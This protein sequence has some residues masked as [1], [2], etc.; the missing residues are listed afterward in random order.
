MAIIKFAIPKGSLE[1]ATFQ[2]L[3]QAGYDV[4]GGKRSYRPRVNDPDITL[5]M[6]RPQEIPVYVSEGIEDIAITGEDWISETKSDVEILC[7]LEY[8]RVKLVAGV[9]EDLPV[10][11]LSSLLEFLFAQ[12]RPV[13]IST[14]YLKICSDWVK[15]NTIY[16]NRF[17]DQDPMIVTP[18]WKIGKNPQVSIFLSFG[19]TEA[20]PPEVAD[21]VMDVTETGSTFAAN[22]IKIIE[23]VM[24]SYA[25]LIANKGALADPIR[26]EK[27][28][29]VLALFRGVV[30]GRRNLHIFVNVKMEN[31]QKLLAALPALKRPT[32][33]PLSDEG[34]FSVNTVLEKQK[35]LQ[36]LPTLRKLAQ[37]LVVHEPRQIL[38]LEEIPK[39]D[40]GGT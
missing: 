19:A 28:Y 36:I 30:S 13:R 34:W 40:E 21:I 17:G 18:W 3:S 31:L 35:F 14:E 33:N 2:F 9:P 22:N 25:V 15:S 1:E 26:R 29:D 23:T 12:N 4:S 20:K 39:G 7:N 11:S 16:Q 5:K 37:G 32:V 27:I 6:L 10:D 8:G 38:P 24:E